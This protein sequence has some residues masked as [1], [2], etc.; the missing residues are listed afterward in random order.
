[1]KVAIDEDHPFV[2]EVELDHYGTFVSH[3]VLETSGHC[4]KLKITYEWTEPF[5]H[6]YSEMSGLKA[7]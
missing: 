4:V 2:N 1:V 6:E 3:H 5:G 7:H